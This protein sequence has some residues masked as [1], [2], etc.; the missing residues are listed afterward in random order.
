VRVDHAW[1]LPG[2]E[3]ECTLQIGGATWD[4]WSVRVGADRSGC[5]VAAGHSP[6]AAAASPSPAAADASGDDAGVA[7]RA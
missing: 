5:G 6:A 3:P 2:S 4:G 7:D 1:L